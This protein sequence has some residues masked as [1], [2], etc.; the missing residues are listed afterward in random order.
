MTGNCL[1]WV[2]YAY[3]TADPFVLAAN[4]PG[5]IL[6]IWLNS[7]AAKLQYAERWRQHQQATAAVSLQ[8]ALDAEG[9]VENSLRQRSP[10][11]GRDSVSGNTH[12]DASPAE[13]EDEESSSVSFLLSSSSSAAENLI[14]VPQERVL[15]RILCA[16]AATA[17]Y[18]GWILP[19]SLSSDTT[20][21][22]PATI[23]GLLVNA[24]LVVFFGAP[25]QSLKEVLRTKQ[26]DSIHRPTLWMNYLNTTFWILYGGFVRF[27]VMIVLPNV[28]GLS[29]GIAQGV[30]CLLYPQRGSSRRSNTMNIQEEEASQLSG[31]DSQE[32]QSQTG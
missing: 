32:G 22:Q 4:I 9:Q 26:S 1:G 3:Y 24:N 21:T 12:W 13:V 11:T 10:F 18:V 8:A 16:W 28:C 27:D 31:G 23:V 5:L 19:L 6:S 20:R 29:L 14:L 2:I 30:L 7:G 25:L 17:V 15:L